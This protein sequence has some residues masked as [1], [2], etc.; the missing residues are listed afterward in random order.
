MNIT[1]FDFKLIVSSLTAIVIMSVALSSMGLVGTDVNA[2]D[3]P[4]LDVQTDRFN[5]ALEYPQEP[6]GRTEGK[7]YYENTD[8]DDVGTDPTVSPNEFAHWIYRERGSNGNV[9]DGTQITLLTPLGTSNA[10]N[11]SKMEV[12]VYEDIENGGTYTDIY[13]L[14]ENETVTHANG[15]TEIYIEMGKIRVDDGTFKATATY[16]VVSHRHV[17]NESVIDSTVGALVRF[18][19]L[20]GWFATFLF[21]LGVNAIAMLASVVLYLTSLLTFLV[22]TYIAI[23]T[24]VP[25]VWQV[26]TL[27]PGV[28]LFME[29]GKIVMVGVSLLPTT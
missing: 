2:S 7:L 4:E 25:G 12:T 27:I 20:L 15:T 29:I 1:K 28:I 9:I 6:N 16:E 18:V 23:A 14:S 11:V 13:T 8:L 19:L 26:F 3:Y 5:Y 10:E 22:T 17:G 24:A 21:E